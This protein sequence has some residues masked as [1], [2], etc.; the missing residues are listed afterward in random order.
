MV[1]MRLRRR[2]VPGGSGQ[3]DDLAVA[4]ASFQL[5]VGVANL[6][7]RERARDRYLEAPVGDHSNDVREQRRVG[8]R[9]SA[10][11]VDP[12][13]AAPRWCT[14]KRKPPELGTLSRA[15]ITASR[16]RNR[17]GSSGVIRLLKQQAAP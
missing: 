9:V 13:G 17:A 7:H 5:P 11:S 14:E 4:V 3:Q 16:S 8:G 1:A 10:L 12:R 2:Q 6:R 15:L